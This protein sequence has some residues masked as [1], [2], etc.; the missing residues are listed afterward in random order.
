MLNMTEV[1]EGAI[2]V[3]RHFAD[4]RCQAAR[5]IGIELYGT[6]REGESGDK[7]KFTVDV[8]NSSKMDPSLRMSRLNWMREKTEAPIGFFIAEMM[9]FS[10]ADFRNQ[11]CIMFTHED[12]EWAFVADVLSPTEVGPFRRDEEFFARLGKPMAQLLDAPFIPKDP[13]G[14]AEH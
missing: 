12:R 5:G 10:E 13:T 2:Y 6:V 14:G 3:A 1:E 7:A 11:I 4:M 9:A 8:A